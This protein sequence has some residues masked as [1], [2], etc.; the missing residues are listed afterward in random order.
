MRIVSISYIRLVATIMIVICHY[1]QAYD[2]KFAFFFNVGVQVF[3]LISG[4]LYGGKKVDFSLDW[5]KRRFLKIAKPYWVVVLAVAT[6]YFLFDRASFSGSELLHALFFSGTINGIEHLWFIPYILVCYFITPYLRILKNES[7]WGIL[8]VVVFYNIVSILTPFHFH[9]SDVT[10]YIIGFLMT[11]CEREDNKKMLKQICFISIPVAL[12]M[13]IYI[14]YVKWMQADFPNDALH[15]WLWS[16]GHSAMGVAFFSIMLL[17]FKN[18]KEN[19][20]T[21]CSDKYSY[22][23]YLV[24]HFF[25]LSPWAILQLP[26]PDFFNIILSLVAILLAAYGLKNIE[27]RILN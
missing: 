10:C 18:M 25:L 14:L 27:T 5:F 12:I 24:H 3:F 26:L 1:L 11:G 9:A 13:N 8:L 16:Y 4:F 21:R 6:C 17:A 15:N 7:F 22:E 2:N 20:L 19:R 23:I